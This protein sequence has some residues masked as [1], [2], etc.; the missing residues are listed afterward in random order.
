MSVILE[1]ERLVCELDT[2][3]PVLKHHWLKNTKGP[4]FRD[5]LA[6]IQ[7]EYLKLKPNY[8]N[9]K[10]L[11]DARNLGELTTEDEE[12]LVTKWETLL[13]VEAG[14]KVHAVIMADDIY[15]DY[16]MEKFKAAA[17]K[18][19]K[20]HGVSLGVFFDEENANQWLNEMH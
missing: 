8:P 13:F 5:Q 20:E 6:E 1:N 7:K 19:H 16:S 4:E 14:V 12:W 17:D 9:L 18:K 2:S 15:A 10:W 3:V 11:A